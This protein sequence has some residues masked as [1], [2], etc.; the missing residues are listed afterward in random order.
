[1]SKLTGAGWSAVLA[2]VGLGEAVIMA[3]GR[4]VKTFLVRISTLNEVSR[5]Y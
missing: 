4:K 1:M 5:T 2:G 3:T